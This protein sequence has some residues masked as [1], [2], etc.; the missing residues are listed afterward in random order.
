LIIGI[1]LDGVCANFVARFRYFLYWHCAIPFAQM[2]EPVGWEL[3]DEWQIEPEAFNRYMTDF[4]QSG[5]F[6]QV[7]LY[8]GT[9]EALQAIRD[10]GYEI[11]II[12]L[13]GDEPDELTR[14]TARRSTEIWLRRTG[15]AHDQLI[16]TGRKEAESFD[17]LLD[18]SPGVLRA[19]EGA[20]KH[21]VAMDRPYN[22]AWEGARVNGW[23]E[24]LAYLGIE[25]AL[26]K[27]A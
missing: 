11:R 2:P 1:D 13:R 18:D 5:Q 21:G 26:G 12:T 25:R 6:A 24:F 7:P 19:V 9:V 10:A 17:V 15:L 16:F 8:P 22:Q 20:G 23:P 27:A 4:I 14:D 3:A